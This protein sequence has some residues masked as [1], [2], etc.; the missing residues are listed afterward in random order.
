MTKDV[1]VRIKGTQ[2][3]EGNEQ[4]EP[5]ALSAKGRYRQVAGRHHIRY[6]EVLEGT[7]DR[8]RNH[9][10][11]EPGR[12]EVHKVGEVNADLIF[13]P[14]M[15]ESISYATR[16]GTL[17]MEVFTKDMTVREGE[18]TLSAVISYTLS[19]G[20]QAVADCSMEMEFRSEGSKS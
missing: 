14:G 11:L 1:L 5:I 20:G 16:F 4:D 18:E 12:V 15:T 9:V 17:P 13:V 3:V 19:S 6:D 10:V 7:T 2:I 8:T